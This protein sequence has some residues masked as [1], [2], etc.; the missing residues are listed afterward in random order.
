MKWID[1]IAVGLIALLALRAVLRARK[2]NKQGCGSGCA[3]CIMA[4]NC[5]EQQKTE[6]T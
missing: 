3:G 4:G 1:W 5:A 2:L 6:Q